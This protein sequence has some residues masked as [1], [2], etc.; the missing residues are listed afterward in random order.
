MSVDPRWRS[1]GGAKEILICYDGL[2]VASLREGNLIV[3]VKLPRPLDL[4]LLLIR[5][6]HLG[7]QAQ[8]PEWQ[9]HDG[10]F[11]LG[12][13]KVFSWLVNI[14]SSLDPEF[15]EDMLSLYWKVESRTT[16]QCWKR[17]FIL[18]KTSLGFELEIGKTQ[19]SFA[20]TLN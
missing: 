4:Q 17:S 20:V 19:S 1:Q 10:C 11:W 6:N 12:E 7:F 15:K 13:R 9:A 2:H 18:W 3:K 14:E 16:T 8:V 5:D